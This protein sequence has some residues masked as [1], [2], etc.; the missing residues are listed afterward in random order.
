MGAR[1]TTSGPAGA[2]PTSRPSPT[3]ATDLAR[4][5]D[6]DGDGSLFE[7]ILDAST[8]SAAT[9][10]TVAGTCSA[11]LNAYPYTSGHVLVLPNRAVAEL[12]ELDADEHRRAVRPAC[13][14]GRR[15]SSARVP[16]RRGQ[17]RA[18]TSGAAAGAGVP[19]HLHVHCLPRWDGDTNFMTAIAETR[20]LPEPLDVSWRQAPR[21]LAGLSSTR[22]SL[23]AGAGPELEGHPVVVLLLAELAALGDDVAAGVVEPGVVGQEAA[24]HPDPIEV[25]E[26]GTPVVGVE[27]G[28]GG[29]VVVTS[30]SARPTTSR[31]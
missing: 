25:G 1:S 27:L 10:C 31:W 19:D 24:Q 2:A 3:T 18:S 30:A 14:R 22:P 5:P 29:Q 4:G 15:P 6:A 8:T 21:R 9:S 12:D 20:V 23:G 17:R 28:R 11:L 16:P 7:R 13:G 26:A